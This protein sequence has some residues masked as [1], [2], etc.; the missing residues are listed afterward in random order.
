MELTW[1]EFEERY[2]PEPEHLETYGE[3]MARVMAADP[4][5]VWTLVDDGEGGVVL[6]S[7]FHFVNRINYLLTHVPH[8]DEPI[9]VIDD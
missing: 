3:D 8:N 5:T 9:E 7:G 6:T 1:D 2:Q 4:K